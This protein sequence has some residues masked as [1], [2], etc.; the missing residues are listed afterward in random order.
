MNHNKHSA[1]YYS[2]IVD[3]DVEQERN[4]IKMKVNRVIKCCVPLFS[5]KCASGAA[6]EVWLDW[7]V[8]VTEKPLKI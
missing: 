6:L 2:Q 3:F 1:N 8:S 7:C 5:M 4:C